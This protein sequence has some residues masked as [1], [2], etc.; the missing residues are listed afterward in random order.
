MFTNKTKQ[1]VN[2]F[3]GQRD[4]GHLLIVSLVAH[5]LI[6]FQNYIFTL[7]IVFIYSI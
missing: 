2:D 6:L 4:R 3:I 5:I 1:T 7:C